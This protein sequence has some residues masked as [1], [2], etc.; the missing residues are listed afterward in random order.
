MLKEDAPTEYCNIHKGE[1]NVPTVVGLSAA[2]ARS[3][4]TGRGFKCSVT[5][6]SS[7]GSEGSV[8][9]QSPSGGSKLSKGGTVTIRVTRAS[10]KSVPNVVGMPEADAKLVLKNAGF[11]VSVSIVPG[12][13]GKV[14]GQSPTGKAKA[15]STV[16]ISVGDGTI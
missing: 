10:S 15:G 6:G 12:E 5:Y 11:N 13:A 3:A 7:S 1:S 4:I 2:E 9:S 16:T 8:Y 14:M